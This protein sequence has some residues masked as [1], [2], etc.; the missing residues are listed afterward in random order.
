L[1]AYVLEDSRNWDRY[2]PLIEFTYN[3]NFHSSIEITPYEVLYGRKC[4]TNLCWIEFV[5]NLLLGHEMIQQ[6]T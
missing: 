5:E 1:R 6:T 3:N 4:K 2:L